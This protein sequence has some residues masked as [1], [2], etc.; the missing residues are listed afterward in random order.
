MS[1]IDQ[2]LSILN[3]SKTMDELPTATALVGTDWAIIWNVALDRAEKISVSTISGVGGWSWIEGSNVE[4]AS[5]NFDTTT[6]EIGD[7]VY[8]KKI[9]NNSDPVTLVGW[10]YNGGDKQLIA[11]YSQNQAIV[12]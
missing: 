5:T 12:T 1:V 3:N 4:K 7:E 9:T 2:V 11:S 10:T 8:F 6:L